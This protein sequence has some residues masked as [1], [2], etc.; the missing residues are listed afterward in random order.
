[1][2]GS[3][4]VDAGRGGARS[5]PRDARRPVGRR[6]LGPPGRPRRHDPVRRSGRA[7][8]ERSD[9]G[10]ARRA[11]GGPRRRS[12]PHRSPGPARAG[13]Q[14]GRGGVD[15]GR[16]R[17]R[18]GRRAW[19]AGERPSRSNGRADRRRCGP[20]RVPLRRF[21]AV[22]LAGDVPR[23]PVRRAPARADP[24]RDDAGAAARAHG[25][26]PRRCRLR[27]LRQPR[28]PRHGRHRPGVR[29]GT[30][31]R[32]PRPGPPGC[33]RP[34]RLRPWRR[35]RRG[36]LVAPRRRRHRI[37]TRVEFAS[38][39]PRR[40]GDGAPDRGACG[41]HAGELRRA[42]RDR[43]QRRA[44]VRGHTPGLRRPRGTAALPPAPG[45]RR[46]APRPAP[47]SRHRAD[48]RRRRDG[49]VALPPRHPTHDPLPDRDAVPARPRP[50][51]PVR[52]GRRSPRLRRIRRRRAR[53]PARPGAAAH[54]LDGLRGALGAGPRLPP[55][56]D[57]RRPPHAGLLRAPGRRRAGRGRRPRSRARPA[58]RPLR[59][60]PPEPRRTGAG[61]HRVR[62]RTRG[63]ASRGP[64]AR[65]TDP[66]PRPRAEPLPRGRGGQ[67][68][69]DG[70]GRP[71]RDRGAEPR[72]GA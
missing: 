25:P 5:G 20:R 65:V 14:G 22:G 36:R 11:G 13:A 48:P 55:P 72:G 6:A 28:R 9:G 71:V 1:M 4:S 3:P 16:G 35:P 34:G 70:R 62:H 26:P 46:R 45:A 38:R 33:R 30:G 67:R 64:A 17:P 54:R 66:L 37:G 19:G 47:D 53:P 40:R 21:H 24:L 10:G 29:R 31:R 58:G 15:R 18:G 52:A 63:A 41:R 2:G 27:V 69:A 60:A 68:G 49:R 32:C 42:R 59:A 56:R 50:D 39:L 8:R 12:A 43:R 57:A 44:G 7:A 51:R 61:S 23:R